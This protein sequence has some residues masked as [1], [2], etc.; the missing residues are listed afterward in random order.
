LEKE[1]VTITV[2]IDSDLLTEANKV[3]EPLGLTL[4]QAFRA[5]LYWMVENPEEATTLLLKWKA[6]HEAEEK[7]EK[8]LT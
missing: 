7:K 2:E 8:R 1:Y 3:L 6:E 5:F 4:E